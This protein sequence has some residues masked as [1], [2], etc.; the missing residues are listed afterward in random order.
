[1]VLLFMRLA[2]SAERLCVSIETPKN[3]QQIAVA[4]SQ[5]APPGAERRSVGR[6]F[7]PEASVT[8]ARV[9]R[10]KRAA[11][12][13]SNRPKTRCAVGDHHA[14]R[15]PL[16]AFHADAVRRRVGLAA[17]QKCTEHFH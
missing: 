7:R 14:D 8:A 11:S 2:L 3:P 17:I 5:F 15:A 9:A 10:A 12:G 4:H 13:L 16:L 6:L 1:M